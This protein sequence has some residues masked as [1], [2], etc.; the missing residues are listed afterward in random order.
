MR[1]LNMIRPYLFLLIVLFLAACSAQGGEPTVSL[2]IPTAAVTADAP[3]VQATATSELP[4]PPTLA[5]T[6][7]PTSQPISQPTSPPPA[8]STGDEIQYQVAFVT[9]NDTLNVRSGPGVVNE[10]IG[11]L[12][13]SASGIRIT[14]SGQ[15]VAGSTWV[16]IAA[17]ALTGWVNGRYLAETMPETTFCQ[18][19][20]VSKLVADLKTAVANQDGNLLAQLIHPERGLRIHHA[21]WNPEVFIT[22]ADARQIF[23]SAAGYDWGVQDGSGL[24][25]VGSFKDNIL[26]LLQQDL[27]LAE[28]TSCNEILHGGT[29]GFVRLPDGYEAVQ[30]YSL[31]RPGTDEFAGMNWGTWVVGVEQ[32]QGTYYV[33]FLVHFQWEI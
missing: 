2:V 17:G 21:W 12:A 4:V 11:E 14:G 7:E 16:P 10:V 25:I 32:W 22:Q 5:P 27:I 8:S 23:T 18:S 3:A 20:E 9:A 30:Y 28:E 6:T 29:A 33:S 19:A 1:K 24:P 15:V 31:H 26:P 13:P